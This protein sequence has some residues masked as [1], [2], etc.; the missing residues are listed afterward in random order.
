MRAAAIAICLLCG[1]PF[2]SLAD[3]PRV[4]RAMMK[5]MEDSLDNQLRGLWAADPMEVLGLT[6]GSYIGGYGAVF[7]SEVNLAPSAGISPFH[8]THTADELKR[9]HEKKLARVPK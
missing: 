7:Q 8:P 6:Q 4:G 3:K 1:V 9:T 5:A 2:G